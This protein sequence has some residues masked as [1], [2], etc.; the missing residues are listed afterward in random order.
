[1][2]SSRGLTEE[3]AAARNRERQDHTISYLELPVFLPDL[4]HLAHELVPQD[5]ARLHRRDE[6]IEEMEIGAA[7]GG[8]GDFDDGVARIQDLRI[9][10]AL[11]AH[12]VR[13]MPY[14]RFH[15]TPPG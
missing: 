14:Q 11:D 10:Y 8:R 3:A 15:H 1:M 6:A 4:H 2:R 7:D 9:G 12:V 13:C 5:V